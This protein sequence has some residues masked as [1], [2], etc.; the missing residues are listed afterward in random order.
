[1][2]SEA[3]QELIEWAEVSGDRDPRVVRAREAGITKNRI[4]TLTGISRATIDRILTKET[5]TM[6]GSELYSW[7][8]Y[9]GTQTVEDSI[10]QLLGEFAGSFDMEG[11]ADA[12]RAEINQRLSPAGIWLSGREFSSDTNPAPDGTADLIRQAVADV[13][14]GALAEK[15]DMA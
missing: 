2:N 3:E 7:G 4:H 11:L 5:T 8:T 9:F 13:D 6:A 10:S 15:F 14:L 1:M 12:Y